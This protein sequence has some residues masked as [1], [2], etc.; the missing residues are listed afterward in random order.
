MSCEIDSKQNC[1]ESGMELISLCNPIGDDLIRVMR[2]VDPRRYKVNFGPT[3]CYLQEAVRRN[4]PVRFTAIQ[5]SSGSLVRWS[6]RVIKII[7]TS[8]F[9]SGRYVVSGIIQ[10]RGK[11]WRN[12]PRIEGF[13]PVAFFGQYNAKTRKGRFNVY[14]LI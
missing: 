5:S 1:F 3:E 6:T 8:N 4:L 9:Q 7:N 10:R 14:T 13:L 12:L 11:D 2:K